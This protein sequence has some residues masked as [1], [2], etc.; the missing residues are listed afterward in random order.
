MDDP[1]PGHGFHAGGYTHDTMVD[2]PNCR[3]IA[4]MVS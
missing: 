3:D 4:A 1:N 2:F